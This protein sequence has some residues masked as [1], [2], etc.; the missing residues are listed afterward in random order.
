[1]YMNNLITNVLTLGSGGGSNGHVETIFTFTGNRTESKNISGELENSIWTYD[2]D[3]E[4]YTFDYNGPDRLTKG[5][6]VS[7]DI[8][9]TVTSIGDNAFADCGELTR[10]AIP[11]GVTSIGDGTFSGCR[12]LLSVTIPDSVTSI[13]PYAFQVC[14][15]LTSVTIPDNVESIGESAFEGC[16]GLTIVTFGNSVTSIG[17]G[18]FVGC[19]SLTS[20]TIPSIV[21]YIGEDAFYECTSLT[22]VTFLGKTMEQVQNIEDGEGNTYY[23]WGLDE[24]IINVA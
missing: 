7:V 16:D 18:A 21:T 14:S 1:M 20:V 2:E 4:D 11:D 17:W 24:S 19:S 22:S 23:P 8:G 13:G 12:G 10:V 15:C 9:N 5:D 6:L 3:S